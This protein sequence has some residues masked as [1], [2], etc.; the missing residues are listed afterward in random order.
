MSRRTLALIAAATFVLSGTAYAQEADIKAAVTKYHAAIE[1]LDMSKMAPLWAHDATVTLINPKG[2]IA[3][4]W[5]AVQ[6]GWDGVPPQWSELKITQVD[7]PYVQ[8]KGDV[9]W[10]IG[11]VTVA[12]KSKAGEPISRPTLEVDIFEKHGGT[13][14][15]VSHAASGRS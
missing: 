1:S 10:S 15:L 4:G 6:K 8:I 3:V 9:A 5:D 14:L 7:G 12:G 2:G 11:L 13:W